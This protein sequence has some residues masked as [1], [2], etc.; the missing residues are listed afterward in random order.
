[1]RIL[2]AGIGNVFLGDDAF[3][4]ETVARLAGRELPAGV[5][6][7]D[8]GIR[9]FDLVYAL[10]DGY[11]A[12]VLVDALA[13]GEPAGTLCVLE[14]CLDEVD[15][16]AT[17][18]SHAM[19]PMAVLAMLRQLGGTMPP[20]WIV[21]CEPGVLDPDGGGHMGLSQPVAG[22]VGAAADL[23]EALVRRVAVPAAATARRV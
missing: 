11:D 20:T 21:G 7:A 14:P 4:V 13:R 5:E 15:G 17:L 9:G 16:A 22:A 19:H 6:V 12:V 10:M 18:D 8:F 23:V 1:M 3:G 2:V